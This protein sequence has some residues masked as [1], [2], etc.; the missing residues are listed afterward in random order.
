[1]N[2]PLRVDVRPGGDPGFAR[3]SPEEQPWA[4]RGCS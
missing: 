1:M 2:H 3:F 4:L